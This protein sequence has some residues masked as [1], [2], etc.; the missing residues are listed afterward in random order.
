M[1]KTV[2]ADIQYQIA[3]Y[4][5]R[6]PYQKENDEAPDGFLLYLEIKVAIEN[7]AYGDACQHTDAA[8][9]KVMDAYRIHKHS[10]DYE[11]EHRSEYSDETIEYHMAKLS[12]KT[13]QRQFHSRCLIASCLPDSALTV[14][15][16]LETKKGVGVVSPCLSPQSGLRIAPK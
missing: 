11:V 7:E 14:C 6:Q 4:H 2:Y 1:I 8:C 10:I 3:N 12:I 13:C 5:P 15:W 16:F 9:Y